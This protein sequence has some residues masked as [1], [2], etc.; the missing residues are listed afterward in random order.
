MHSQTT[1]PSNSIDPSS[2]F[3]HLTFNT[4]EMSKRLPPPVAKSLARTIAKGEKLD[5]S[6]V[7]AVALA[8]KEWAL[9]HGATH[10]C[11]WFT[12]LTGSTA[13]KH[14]AFLHP[15]GDGTAGTRFAGD[16]LAFGEPDASSF[17]SGGARQ[18]FEARGYTA[19]DATSPAFILPWRRRRHALHPFRLCLLYRRGSRPQNPLL[20]SI[21]AVTPKPCGS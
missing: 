10:Y 14:D 4:D 21:E 20:R 16:N 19:W 6:I 2:F 13:E 5:P 8:M 9:E 15:F 12:P 3:G 17:P 18:T 1:E 7:D 11:H